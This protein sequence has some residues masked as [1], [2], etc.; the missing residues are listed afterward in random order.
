M[1]LISVLLPLPLTPVTT[2]ITPSGMR[3][4]M[5]CRLCSRAPSTVSHLPVSGR[6]VVAMQDARRAGQV[7][8]RERLRAGHDLIGRALGDDVAA[9]PPRARSQID[10]VIGMTNGVFV[11]LHHQHRIAQV[12]QLLERAE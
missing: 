11:V 5:S 3:M 7:A 1:S 10:H 6:G 12:A 2:V 8:A 9:Q 4:L